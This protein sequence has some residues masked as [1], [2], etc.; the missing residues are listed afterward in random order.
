LNGSFSPRF[1]TKEV[2]MTTG[3]ARGFTNDRKSHW[4][5]G[6]ILGLLLL[7]ALGYIAVVPDYVAAPGMNE[8]SWFAVTDQAM[9]SATAKDEN[10]AD[11]SNA[12][13]EDVAT[14]LASDEHGKRGDIN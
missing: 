5:P 6:L 3:S 12:Q 2:I 8:A 7:G 11:P 4:T 13:T 9:D 14:A 10:A 1:S